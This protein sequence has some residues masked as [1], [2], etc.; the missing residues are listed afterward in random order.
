MVRRILEILSTHK[1]GT[2]LT[3]ALIVS[4]TGAQAGVGRMRGTVVD[5]TGEPIEGVQV[6]ITSAEL[7][8]FHEEKTT[9]KS[10]T[11]MVSFAQPHHVYSYLFVK[12]GYQ[13]LQQEIGGRGTEQIKETFALTRTEAATAAEMSVEAP[14][15]L[16]TNAAITAFNEGIT[17]LKSGDLETARNQLE[18]A[19]TEDP[20]LGQA[21]AALAGVLL[22]EKKYEEALA[23]AQQALALRAA[24]REAL[25]VSYEANRKL[26]RDKE[27]AAASEALKAAEDSLATARRVYNEGGAAYQAEDMDTALAKFSEAASLDP[28]LYDAQHAVA[29]LLLT[30]REFAGAAEAADAALA[31]RPDETRT[32]QVAYQAHNAL[33][34]SDKATDLLIRLSALDPQFGAANLLEQGAQKFNAGQSEEAKALLEGALAVD[35]GQAKAHY[36]LGLYYINKGANDEAKSHLSRF[37]EMTPHD[38]DAGTARDMLVFLQ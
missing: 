28:S 5:D 25:Q 30:R 4:T 3:V 2:L 27:A 12:A 10:G 35:P 23:A 22:D 16:G 26:G 7:T 38:A 31:L 37:L 11:F 32:L 15:V 9:N 18:V 1:M 29:S 33:G 13:S 8:S 6:T 17:A 34:E 36:L 24:D 14:S 19:I 20:E 21:H